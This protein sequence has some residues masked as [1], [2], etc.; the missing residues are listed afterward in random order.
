MSGQLGEEKNDRHGQGDQ[1]A[2][3]I[4]IVPLQPGRTRLS[5]RFG[6]HGKLGFE[7][8]DGQP[9]DE[10]EHHRLGDQT[11]EASKLEAT[12]AD[13]NNPHKNNSRKQILNT[14]V[15]AQSESFP[16]FVTQDNER[17]HDYGQGPGRP[18]NHP[19]PSSQECSDQ[20]NH[21]G[22]V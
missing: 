14:H 9:I 10:P 19:R 3:Q 17:H 8:H 13:L 1:S 4:K 16:A 11:N 18:G 15:R 21:E 7:D 5:G 12:T 6:E 20:A 22:R 2:H